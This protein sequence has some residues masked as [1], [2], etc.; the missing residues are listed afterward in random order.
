MSIERRVQLVENLFL[1]LEQEIAQFQKATGIACPPD[2]GKCCTYT[3]I[4]ASP[5]EFLPWAFHLFLNGEAE[6]QLDALK[7]RQTATC[8]IY[9]PLL[10]IGACSDYP[11][12][13]LNLQAVW[14]CG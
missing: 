3:N 13:G 9:S 4:E 11:Y 1:Q 6:K 10:L 7:L 8:L 14:L 2:C 12:R 5:L